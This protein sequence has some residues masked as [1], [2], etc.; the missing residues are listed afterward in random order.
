MRHLLR[1]Q[2]KGISK[3]P[4]KKNPPQAKWTAQISPNRRPMVACFPRNNNN[5]K[6]RVR[7]QIIKNEYPSR[8][9]KATNKPRLPPQASALVNQSPIIL[10][11]AACPASASRGDVRGTG[12]RGP[13]PWP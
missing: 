8:H 9:N 1:Y 2:R 11:H 12:R 7:S 5:K 6:L 3:K 13:R 4:K 10:Y